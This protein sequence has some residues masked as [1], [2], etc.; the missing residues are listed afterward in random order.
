[1]SSSFAL[2]TV[3]LR[4]HCSTAL[5]TGAC[6]RDRRG[7]RRRRCR[8][9]L[10]LLEIPG[11][12]G[13]A[14][15]GAEPGCR[16]AWCLAAAKAQRLFVRIATLPAETRQALIV[17]ALG[18]ES[19]PRLS[20]V[21]ALAGLRVQKTRLGRRSPRSS[22]DPRRASSSRTSWRA[23]AGPPAYACAPRRASRRAPRP[24]AGSRPGPDTRAWHR[25]LALA[26]P[27]AATAD[28]LADASAQSPRTRRVRVCGKSLRA[29]RPRHTQRDHRT[30]RLVAAADASY[31]QA[32]RWPS[33]S[34][35]HADDRASLRVF[36]RPQSFSSAASSHAQG[37]PGAR[38]TSCSTP[39]PGQS[40]RALDAVHPAPG[41]TMIPT[42]RSSDPAAAIE[43]GGGAR[44]RWRHRAARGAARA[45]RARRRARL[46]R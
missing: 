29:R 37:P 9:P 23:H 41:R 28:E 26:S 14:A 7:R 39:Q 46:C 16:G 25:A 19:R 31:R 32:R 22:S 27:D 8:S 1:M 10:A 5:R 45:G 2:S 12:D 21:V 35:R 30:K 20:D 13:G 38:A 17:V 6:C 44:L 3:P 36:G 11:P 34:S 33:T 15:L 42:L 18:G 43:T 24:G 40:V 4:S